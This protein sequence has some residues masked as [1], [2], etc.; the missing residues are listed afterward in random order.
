MTRI[1]LGITLFLPRLLNTLGARVQGTLSLGLLQQFLLR[2][3]VGTLLFLERQ[4]ILIEILLG[5]L[6]SLQGLDLAT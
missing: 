1:T 2:L 4:V 5:L 6:R 3:G